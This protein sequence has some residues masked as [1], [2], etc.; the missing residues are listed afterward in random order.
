VRSRRGQRGGDGGRQPPRLGRRRVLRGEQLLQRRLGQCGD[1]ADRGPAVP[2]R[3]GQVGDPAL[4]EL[5]TPRCSAGR[6]S[7]VTAASA[8]PASRP[9]S[10][11]APLA[12]PSQRGVVSRSTTA[13]TPRTL[14]S[15]CSP[16]ESVTT[17]VLPASRTSR[18]R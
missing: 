1:D 7:A 5:L 10:T 12:T 14:A 2:V 18:S 16:P 8:R 17:T 3:A 6:V 4:Q 11:A 13:G 9:V 15:S